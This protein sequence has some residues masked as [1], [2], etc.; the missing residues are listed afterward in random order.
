[1]ALL[2]LMTAIAAPRVLPVAS[3]SSELLESAPST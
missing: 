2:T 1:M 3:G